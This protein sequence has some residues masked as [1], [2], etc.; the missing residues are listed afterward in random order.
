M[1]ACDE[2]ASCILYW[3]FLDIY[4]HVRLCALIRSKKKTDEKEEKNKN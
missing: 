4:I 1:T 2:I 3:R